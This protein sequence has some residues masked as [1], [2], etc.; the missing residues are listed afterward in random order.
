MDAWIMLACVAVLFIICEIFRMP[1]KMVSKVI[2]N[3]FFGM[4]L[5]Y[6]LN[7]IGGYFDYNLPLNKVNAFMIGILGVP[8]VFAI[9]V[10]KYLNI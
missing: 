2:L 3:L 6:L 1:K 7:Y 4:G 9:M 10:L 5:L 8:G